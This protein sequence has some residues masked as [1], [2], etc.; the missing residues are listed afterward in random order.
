MPVDSLG[1]VGIQLHRSDRPQRLVAQFAQLLA[2][3]P[4]DV[5]TPELVIVPARGVERW[6]TQQL[7]HT[8]GATGTRNGVC[9][10]LRIMTPGSL[11]SLLVDRDRDDPWHTDRLVW[12]TLQAIDELCGT[13]GFEVITHHLGAGEPILDDPRAEWE[14]RARQTRRYAV[15]RRLAGLFTAYNRERPQMV[16]DWEAGRDTDGF[17]ADLA[18]DLVWQPPLWRRTAELV[19]ERAG[20]A[21]T[22]LQRHQRVVAELNAGTDNLDLPDRLSFFGYTHLAAADLQLVRALGTRREVHLWLPHPSPALWEAIAGRG[23]RSGPPAARADDTTA[24]LAGHQLLATLGRDVRELQQCLEFL[25]PLVRDAVPGEEGADNR[26]RMLQADVRANRPPDPARV[27]QEGD[28]SV[29]IHACHGRARQVEVLREILTWLVDAPHGGLQP[30]DILVMCPDIEHFASLLQAS[31]GF[32]VVSA[33]DERSVRAHPGQRLR[34]HLADRGLGATNPLIDL[35][36]AVVDLVSGRLTVSEVLDFAGQDV[37]RRKFGFDDDELAQLA[38]WVADSGVR[39]GYDAPHRGEYGLGSLDSNTWAHGLDRIA[40]GVAVAADGAGQAADL[41]PIDDVG[42]REIDLAGRFI[43]LVQ[44]VKEAADAVRVGGLHGGPKGSMTV[45]EWMRW[46][47]DTVSDFA[48][49]DPDDRWQVAQLTRELTAVA[50]AAGDRT[51]LR[52]GDIRS[53]LAHRWGGRPTRSNFRTGAITVCSM[54]PMRSV[55]H[56]AVVVL[57]LDDGVYPRSPII[58]GDDAL[59]RTPRVGERDLRSEDREL[60]LDAVMAASDYF[61]AIYSGFDEH[62]GRQRPP[63]VPLQELIAVAQRTATG[64]TPIVRSHPLQ[65]FDERNFSVGA[66]IPGGTFDRPALQGALS[67]RGFHRHPIDRPDFVAAPLAPRPERTVTL[68]ELIS[69]LQNPAR[70]F[71][72]RRLDVAV[73]R[74]I[75]LPDDGLPI[76]LDGLDKWAIGDRVLGTITGGGI[77]LED[78]LRRE[79]VRGALPPG[80]LGDTAGNA[81]RTD[82]TWI[83]QDLHLDAGGDWPGRRSVD[84]RME[85]PGADGLTVLT[86]VVGD[87]FGDDLRLYSF[88]RVNP[89]QLLGAWVQ[90]LALTVAEPDRHHSAFLRGKAT[91]A[92]VRSPGVDS[93]KALLADLLAIRQSGMRF[94]MGVPPRTARLFAKFYRS[95]LRHNAP[96]V[97][98][99]IAMSRARGEWEGTERFGGENA[100]VYWEVV[101]GRRSRIVELNRRDG[102]RHFGPRIWD[103]IEEHVHE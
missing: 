54:V 103:P 23:G 28:L 92:Q 44:R 71:L 50:D 47:G 86:G 15:A 1:P 101:L 43:D 7:A 84:V 64:P 87:V 55:P 39:W 78:A 36:H 90:L 100:D 14:R 4:A 70:E 59:A 26:L 88:S 33:G 85:L 82:I 24:A 18:P 38:S 13:A 67:L 34:V 57:G 62:S 25:D 93:A 21:E 56:K 19:Q 72:R 29:Q 10:G 97:A 42:S 3:R 83:T 49:T 65:A 58:D 9:A 69:F 63:A 99:D 37:V 6:M 35:A 17:G 53:M 74:D 32:E 68:E 80:S 5:F 73:P 16:Q 66:P 89:R 27:A 52:L 2:Q 12:P 75:E 30:R 98:A 22:M 45:Q 94:P 46:L 77:P 11:V 76:E 102:L 60:L 20:L 95:A 79:I 48:E 40:L 31:F 61:V 51:T 41:A 8:L 96:A 81:I 91:T